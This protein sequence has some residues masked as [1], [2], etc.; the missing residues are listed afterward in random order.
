MNIIGKGVGVQMTDRAYFQVRN[1]LRLFDMRNPSVLASD[2]LL[3]YPD[4]D[5]RN[6]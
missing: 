6:N 5:R 3:P 1:V 4:E 2:R